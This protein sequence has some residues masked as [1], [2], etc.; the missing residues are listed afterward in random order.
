MPKVGPKLPF[1]FMR[2]HPALRLLSLLDFPLYGPSGPPLP[3]EYEF[4]PEW[5]KA[6]E[7]NP[8]PY[9]F[10]WQTGS[11][12]TTSCGVD[13]SDVPEFQYG[14]DL[15]VANGN[16]NRARN[17]TF[18]YSKAGG[19]R[20]DR[21]QVW[22]RAYA[23]RDKPLPVYKPGRIVITPY[24]EPLPD[25]LPWLDPLTNPPGSTMPLVEVPPYEIT[26]V[27]PRLNAPENPDWGYHEPERPT[28]PD[29]ESP[30]APSG[31]P[32]FGGP[33]PGSTA[34]PPRSPQRGYPQNSGPR[35]K[36]PKPG[37]KERKFT[38]PLAQAILAVW[39]AAG[40]SKDFG[41]AIL[42][43][44]PEGTCAKGTYAQ[45]MN[46]LYH[47]LDKVDWADAVKNVILNEIEDRS[48]GKIH[49]ALD[50]VGIGVGFGGTPYVKQNFR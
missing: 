46:C 30:V 11:I 43:A 3:G 25:L 27:R 37:T 9:D 7:L 38:G 1:R 45:R 29:P 8:P 41:E 50:R 33:P 26:P 19:M 6:C 49:Q 35:P 22:Y 36:R 21:Q 2:F 13:F 12:A 40:E 42:D 17:I 28:R 44:L 16:S 47:N 18:G 15:F 4:T 10:G 32:W 31:P 24:S 20:Q 48:F 39:D 5:I 34:A 23:D 14:D